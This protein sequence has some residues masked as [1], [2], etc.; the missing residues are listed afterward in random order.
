MG[1]DRC[2]RWVRPYASTGYGHP[3]VWTR[4]PR[5]GLPR[6][7]VD[8]GLP[9]TYDAEKDTSV[10][11]ENT[12]TAVVDAVEHGLKIRPLPVWIRTLWRDEDEEGELEDRSTYCPE[13]VATARSCRRALDRSVAAKPPRVTFQQ[14]WERLRAAYE[15]SEEGQWFDKIA[16]TGPWE[17]TE[18]DDG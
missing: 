11:F 15:Y 16:P 18:Y 17:C 1:K 13:S 9:P 5:R 12:Y 14:G 4:Q 6:G 3:A 8:L 10:G 2:I 7:R